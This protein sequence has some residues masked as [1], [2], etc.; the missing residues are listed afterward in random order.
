M[1]IGARL[2]LWGAAK[3]SGPTAR[4]YVQ[5]G[6]VAMWDGIENAGWGQHDASATAWVDLVGGVTV[7]G[8]SFGDKYATLSNKNSTTAASSSYR[9]DQDFTLHGSLRTLPKVWTNWTL[10]GI[11]TGSGIQNGFCFIGYDTGYPLRYKNAYAGTTGLNLST[12]AVS[13]ADICL[14]VVFIYSTKTAYLY[15]NGALSGSSSIDASLWNLDGKNLQLGSV[16]YDLGSV[17]DMRNYNIIY[18]N[19]ALTA[20]EVAANYAIDKARFNLP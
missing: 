15:V 1:L 5:D 9:A 4:D 20:A 13:G 14:D 18:Y 17:G 8:R 16:L 12:G 10:L 11:G 6:L 3:P 19:R 2:A 7:S